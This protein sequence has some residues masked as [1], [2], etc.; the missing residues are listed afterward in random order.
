M[1]SAAAPTG[2]GAIAV[3]DHGYGTPPNDLVRVFDAFVPIE[4][5]GR[6]PVSTR[7]GLGLPISRRLATL[8]G[9][10]LTAESTPGEGSTFRLTLPARAPGGARAVADE[11]E[12]PIR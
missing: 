12:P 4:H 5:S 9:G 11:P 6:E 2:G 8:L 10:T 7:A 3:R 1:S